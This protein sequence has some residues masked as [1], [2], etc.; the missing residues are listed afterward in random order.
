M[1]TL[2]PKTEPLTCRDGL[3]LGRTLLF[4][5][6][7]DPEFRVLP[8]RAAPASAEARPSRGGPWQRITGAASARTAGNRP[9]DASRP[10]GRRGGDPRARWTHG[11][12]VAATVRS[13][14]S[15]AA[16]SSGAPASPAAVW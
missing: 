2:E 3:P 9:A 10:W 5:V 13:P 4:G 14:D 15:G 1:R 6:A 7:P 11:T 16:G 8:A 12:A